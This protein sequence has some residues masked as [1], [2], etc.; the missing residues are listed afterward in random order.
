MKNTEKV[1]GSRF[2]VHGSR[3]RNQGTR[4]QEEKKVYGVTKNREDGSY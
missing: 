3:L 1:H 4:V 2:M